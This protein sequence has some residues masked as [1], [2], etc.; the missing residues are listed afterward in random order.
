VSGELRVDA[1]RFDL[2]RQE[3]LAAQLVAVMDAHF[4]RPTTEQKKRILKLAE[5]Q[6]RASG[7]HAHEETEHLGEFSCIRFRTNGEFTGV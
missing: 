2:V 3:Q 4:T 5:G 1:D 7:D 6:I